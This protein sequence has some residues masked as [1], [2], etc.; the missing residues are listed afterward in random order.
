MNTLVDFQHF[1]RHIVSQCALSLA[2]ISK[3]QMVDRLLW[4][5]LMS[6]IQSV[7]L[8]VAHTVISRALTGGFL[9]ASLG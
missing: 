1:Y 8:H 6:R 2:M 5:M 9:L 7:H 4:F 3:G